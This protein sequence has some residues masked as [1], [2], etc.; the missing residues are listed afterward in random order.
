MTVHLPSKHV[1]EPYP[2]AD[3]CCLVPNAPALH[4][5]S[6]S[7]VCLLADQERLNINYLTTMTGVLPTTK[8][9][10]GLR[11]LPLRSRM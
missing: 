6:N 7:L 8:S 11:A 10:S 5:H 2:H 1:H 4:Q 9:I 3:A